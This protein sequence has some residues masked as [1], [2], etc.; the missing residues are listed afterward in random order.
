MFRKELTEKGLFDALFDKF[1][2]HLR[3]N[4]LIMNEEII[5]NGSFVEVPRQRNSREEN[6]LI[7]EGKGDE[8]WNA[9][10]G[11]TEDDK[12]HKANKKR[13]KDTD[14]RWTKKGGEKFYGYKAHAKRR[15]RMEHVFGYM[16]ESMHGMHSR[17]VG[18]LRNAAQIIFT[19][20]V[21]NMLRCEQIK[22]L[23]MN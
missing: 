9:E 18:F 7:K 5:I 20:L 6:K 13:H 14:A 11:D 15:A 12:K 21:N 23:A 17:A 22:R 3:D 8:L 1:N 4:N 19:C 2:Q 10:E 16:E